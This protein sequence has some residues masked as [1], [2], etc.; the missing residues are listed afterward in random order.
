MKTGKT[1][2]AVTASQRR[3]ERANLFSR[4]SICKVDGLQICMRSYLARPAAHLLCETPP[5]GYLLSFQMVTLKRTN[6]DRAGRVGSEEKRGSVASTPQP[7][8]RPAVSMEQ[9]RRSKSTGSEPVRFSRSLAPSDR[10][11]SCLLQIGRRSWS[12][13]ERGEERRRGKKGKD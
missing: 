2:R 7:H 11:P 9:K 6:C 5:G 4:L 10:S 3:R 13:A 12:D 8:S 1:L